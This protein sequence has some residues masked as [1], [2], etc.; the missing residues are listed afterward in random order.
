MVEENCFGKRFE[1]LQ[2]C[3]TC[4]VQNSCKGEYIIDPANK[5]RV[6]QKAFHKRFNSN[7]IWY[8]MR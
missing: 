3:R 5:K 2:E 8:D 6:N 4:K 1:E 7:G